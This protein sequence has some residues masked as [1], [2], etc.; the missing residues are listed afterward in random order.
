MQLN[1]LVVKIVIHRRSLCFSR[2]LYL[3]VTSIQQCMSNLRQH[4]SLRSVFVRVISQIDLHQS[5]HRA[6]LGD[7][8][9]PRLAWVQFL[10]PARKTNS[11]A[12][13]VIACPYHDAVTDT[14]TVSVEG[15]NKIVTTWVRI[16]TIYSNQ[17]R[18][19][20]HSRETCKSV[21]RR[22]NNVAAHLRAKWP[23][24]F[25]KKLV[26]LVKSIL[27]EM[28]RQTS[29]SS[30]TNIKLRILR[31]HSRWHSRV[32]VRASPWDSNAGNYGNT[33]QE[34]EKF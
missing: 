10:Q 24:T 17:L 8:N 13:L 6:V 26:W 28:S 4:H 25:A 31:E 18:N 14:R 27:Q 32:A 15:T 22:W 11:N 20:T 23:F 3:S 33:R 21:T 30:I 12:R 16:I 7:I 1:L 2:H 29:F 34:A 5:S 19:G 9:L